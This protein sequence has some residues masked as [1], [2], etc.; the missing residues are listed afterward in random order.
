PGYA[1][2]RIALLYESNKNEEVASL[3]KDLSKSSLSK[4]YPDFPIDL[5]IEG[6][7]HTLCIINALY[8]RVF[9]PQ[10][11]PLDKLPLGTLVMQIVKLYARSLTTDLPKV[12][13]WDSQESQCKNL[14]KIAGFIDGVGILKMLRHRRRCLERALEGLGEHGAVSVETSPIGE[15]E[16]KSEMMSLPSALR[17][18][19]D[20]MILNCKFSSQ[21]LNRTNRALS[22]RDLPSECNHQ[23]L[24]KYTSTDIQER[25]YKNKAILNII[26]PTMNY[27]QLPRLVSIMQDRIERDK[28]L[29][30]TFSQLRKEII[31]VPVDAKLA[32]AL[33]HYSQ[34][35]NA[36]INAL[37]VIVNPSGSSG[38]LETKNTPNP[39]PN[40]PV[41]NS[42]HSYNN[43]ASRP[44]EL[45]RSFR[46]LYS[47]GRLQ[48][49]DALDREWKTDNSDNIKAK[50]LFS[51]MV[52]SFR[53]ASDTLDRIR[54]CLHDIMCSSSVAVVPKH[55]AAVREVENT[56]NA[57]LRRTTQ[58]YD[59]SNNVQE[60]IN[61]VSQALYDRPGLS[62]SCAL[63]VYVTEC[64]HL[65]WSIAV[66][67][68]PLFL[69]YDC[70]SFDSM[71]HERFHT[72]DRESGAILSYLWPSLLEKQSGRCVCKGVVI[73]GV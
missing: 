6:I 58:N 54:H 57:Y 51:V 10:K 20:R 31:S 34:A 35:F 23:R 3:I 16:V 15:E 55:E 41:Y 66:Q 33:N 73:T 46:S 62:E 2:R 25:L 56:F 30:L 45:A 29:L 68:P 60:V 32:P 38:D 40:G 65:S 21:K 43:G 11:F 47:D 12:P 14:L 69:E 13:N 37:K 4:I 52:L 61:Q 7:P 27:A 1:L 67:T 50:L 63:R 9:M 48:A 8:S 49:M 59:L 44:S 39:S 26:E 19:L 17:T 18:E 24:M 71:R 42:F 22:E 70:Q 36:V 53:S 5:F 28:D 72:S 64:I